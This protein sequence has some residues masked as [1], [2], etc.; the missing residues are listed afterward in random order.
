MTTTTPNKTQG[1]SILALQSVAASSVLISSAIDV[2]GKLEATIYIHFGRRNATA[3][4]AGVNIRVE[5]SAK[6]S[7]DGHWFPLASISTAFAACEA[8]AVSGTVA[9]GTNVIMVASTTN[10]AAGDIIY[11]DNTTIANSEWGRVKSIVTNT[12]ITIEDNLVNAQTGATL[13][14]SAEMYAL[15]FTELLSIGRIRVVADGS[16]FTQAFAIEV[17]MTTADSY[18]TV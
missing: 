17:E 13:Y 9:S 2:S 4:G 11:I 7:G 1:T 15:T 10:L 16:L 14:D 6:S 18:T 8:E 12:S 3:A 5:A